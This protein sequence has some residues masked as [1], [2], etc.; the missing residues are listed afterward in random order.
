M[1]VVTFISAIFILIIILGLYSN[2]DKQVSPS[3]SY[4]RLCAWMCFAGLVLDGLF[5]VVNEIDS[6]DRLGPVLT[7]FS[8]VMTDGMLVAF[9]FYFQSIAEI[10][11]KRP[12]RLLKTTIVFVC[13][14]FISFTIGSVTGKF[15]YYDNGETVLGP[16]Y[17]FIVVFPSICVTLLFIYIL[18]HRRTLGRLYT[19]ALSSFFVFTITSGILL[20]Y[21]PFLNTSYVATALTMMVSYV[22]IQSRTISEANV[23]ADTYNRLSVIDFLTGLKNR[24]GFQE[25]VD[26]LNPDAEVGVFFCDINGLKRTNDNY[27]HQDGDELIKRMANLLVES[28]PD[29]DIFRISGDEFVVLLKLE[30]G[31]DLEGRAEAIRVVLDENDHIASLGFSRGKASELKELVRQAEEGMYVE[32]RIH[33]EKYRIER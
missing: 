6:L 18:M 4:F 11:R 2:V 22:F 19:I 17:Y 27:G 14:D 9:A 28:F 26:N 23:R 3:V 5:Y 24:R 12:G 7:Y 21:F 13:L 30:R 1:I 20:I 33:H 8:Y 25:A 16:F 32:K 31:A 10:G 29:G 15:F